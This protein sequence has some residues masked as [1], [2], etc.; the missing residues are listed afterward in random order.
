[1]L[2]KGK[3]TG[4]IW[5]RITAYGFTAVLI[6]S[7]AIGAIALKQLFEDGQ[8]R[9][10][11][12]QDSVERLAAEHLEAQRI[13]AA[14][15]AIQIASEPGLAKLIADHDRTGLL[16]RFGAD[17][18]GIKSKSG[19]N[20]VWMVDSQG[21]VVAR[22]HE[23]QNAGDSLIGRPMIATALTTGAFT[24][25]N[26]VGRLGLGIYA[27]APASE[28]GKVAGLVSVGTTLSNA[29]FAGLKRSMDTDF[30]VLIPRGAEFITQNST[31]A[32][33]SFLTPDEMRE[34]TL[35]RAVRRVQFAQGKTYAVSGLPIR[36]FK[37]S[38]IG[39]LELAT[40][41]TGVVA[42]RQSALVET[43]LVSL[44]ICVLA[45]IGF[46]IVARR[47]GGS[48]AELNLAM[49]RVAA[50]E[51]STAIP[52]VDRSD[53]VG[54]MARTVEVFKESAAKRKQLE[55]EAV[56]AQLE[57]A[58]A[59]QRTAAERATLAEQ[60]TA[61]VEGLAQGL[62][63]LADGDLT[64]SLDKAF[65]P[66]YERLRADFNAAAGRLRAALGAI[67]HNTQAIRSGAGEIA[68][69]ADDLSR[70]TEQQAAALEQ[71]AAALNEITA[72]VASTAQGAA[73]A[74][75]IV[76][77][78]KA[79]AERS[80]EIVR[81]AVGAM[82]E[83]EQSA[84]EIGKINGVIDEIAFQ[85]SLLALNAGVEAARAGDSGRGFAVVASEVRALAQRSAD[86]AK[87]IKSLVL[88]STSQVERG[89][90]LVGETGGALDT[91]VGRVTEAAVAIAH[92]AAAAQ[93]QS[94][95][96]REVNGGVNQMDQ[97]TQQNAAMVQQSTAA[98]HALRTEA[99]ELTE[100]TAKFR[101]GNTQVGTPADKQSRVAVP[102][103]VRPSPIPA[104]NALA[105]TRPAPA[106]IR[107]VSRS[108]G[109]AP[110]AIR[111][112]AVAGG[113]SDDGWE[114]F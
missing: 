1:M 60:Q 29:Y 98:S 6:S 40:D 30:A 15:L 4:P 23:P 53:E 45:L 110:G 77:L 12:Q 65:A 13:A 112:K 88:A 62:S 91:I 26:E 17:F 9:I 75:A 51:L 79:D 49:E 64:C 32:G 83:I 101:I 87:E 11:Y 113:S 42:A 18:A 70:R 37:N 38:A 52:G 7:L 73:S 81:Q 100:L 35:G 106:P 33:G 24:S 102:E 66:E 57:I 25:G 28:D 2:A 71:T 78:A 48:V 93:E 19:L 92:I 69:A 97:V 21:R 10:R 31:Y 34:V 8:A 5:V 50:G 39:V 105:R 61:V 46:L 99:E 84:R 76:Q 43:G 94:V 14:A 85:T 56:A 59:T 20:L 107:N 36:N 109:I 72:T 111:S 96:L 3:I 41:V 90:A 74:T 22:M 95:G 67:V 86:A 27:M 55:E 44:G 108:A 47:L 54:A 68:T 89:V 16:A 80:G 63:R 104:R 58:A 114:E 82:S 103:K